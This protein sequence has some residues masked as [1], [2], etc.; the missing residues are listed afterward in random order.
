M[1]YFGRYDPYFGQI[2]VKNHTTIYSVSPA[3]F[4]SLKKSVKRVLLFWQRL[5]KIRYFLLFLQLFPSKSRSYIQLSS[6]IFSKIPMK[7]G[8]FWQ[9]LQLKKQSSNYGCFNNNY[10][11]MFILDYF[12]KFSFQNRI[13]SYS[14]LDPQF[15]Q[16]Y[17]G[18]Q[19]WWKKLQKLGRCYNYFWFQIYLKHHTIIS[20]IST[21]LLHLKKRHEIRVLLKTI[22]KIWLF[23]IILQIF[24]IK[25][26]SL[27]TV[28]TAAF[29]FK[30][31]WKHGCSDRIAKT[32]FVFINILIF[33]KNICTRK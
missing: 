24:S 14:S 12:C 23:L 4:I 30:Y 8:V 29:F 10:E 19:G 1:Q 32:F 31:P 17:P 9:I 20:S 16:K 18:K 15:S 13:V 27:H 25:I 33:L 22:T 21:V 7:P 2:S 26:T 5:R 11:N 3:F 6:R 28:S